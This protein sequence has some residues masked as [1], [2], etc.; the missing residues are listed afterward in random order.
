MVYKYLPGLVGYLLSLKCQRVN[1]VFSPRLLLYCKRHH[2]KNEVDKLLVGDN[3]LNLSK[4][5]YA[6][7]SRLVASR[8]DWIKHSS[9]LFRCKLVPLG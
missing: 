8:N 6:L 4:P 9:R 3:S 1:N 7:F 2:T 5:V